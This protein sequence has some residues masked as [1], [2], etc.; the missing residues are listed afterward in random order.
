MR[1]RERVCVYLIGRRAAYETQNGVI[2]L[3]SCT[4]CVYFLSFTFFSRVCGSLVFNQKVCV[5]WGNWLCVFVVCA[6][7]WCMC[8]GWKFGGKFGDCCTANIC[9]VSLFHACC[10]SVEMHCSKATQMQCERVIGKRFGISKK[11]CRPVFTGSIEKP[12]S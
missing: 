7:R 10:K 6:V 9:V 11:F 3:M 8:L 4:V 2:F 5:V 12:R 1:E